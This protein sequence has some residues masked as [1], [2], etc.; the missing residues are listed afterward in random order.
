MVITVEPG[1]CFIYYS[2]IPG[3][4]FIEAILEPAFKD[5][6][7]N[8]FLNVERIKEFMNF[9]GVRIE[10]DVI[11]TQLGIENMTSVPRSVAEIEKVMAEGRKEF[12]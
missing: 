5:S 6:S 2:H 3:I 9:G 12:P 10:D 7:K 4:Y 8:Q 1:K 11:I